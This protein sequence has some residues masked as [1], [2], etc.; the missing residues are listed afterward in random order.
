M[1]PSRVDRCPG[2]PSAPWRATTRPPVVGQRRR[3]CRLAAM[4]DPSAVPGLPYYTGPLRLRYVTNWL[5]TAAATV[6]FGSL[7]IVAVP[8]DRDGRWI[9]AI[10]RGWGT[11]V[12]RS[13][14]VHLDVRGD[15]HL[16]PDET[17]VL[18][19]N[20]HSLFDIPALLA[21]I[22]LP[23]RML[24]KASLFRIPFL[25]WYMSRVG[26]IPVERSDPRKAVA[27]IDQ[28]ARQIRAGRSVLVFAEGTRS[29][30]GELRAF[31]GGG[32]RLARGTGL[33]IVPVAVSNSGRLMP[34]GARRAEPGIIRV[35]IGPAIPPEAASDYRE[36]SG[37][38]RQEILRLA[39]PALRDTTGSAS[40][41]AD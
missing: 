9:R 17:Y 8:F 26:Y 21:G 23:L 19:S 1:L 24:A 2:A 34:R 10:G 30:E 28:A 39:G 18:V 36:L 40:R 3:P 12:L 37:R 7:G 31:K 6:V 27:S 16:D 35:R 25:G 29:P 33:P 5:V 11:V 4:S 20:H 13:A 32:F 22:P 38:V 41:G 15:E 14:G